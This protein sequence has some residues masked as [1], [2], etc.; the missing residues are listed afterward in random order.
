ML[1]KDVTFS[2]NSRRFNYNIDGKMPEL[3]DESPH[4]DP[5]VVL[6]TKE[7]IARVYALLGTIAPRKRSVF[8]L[9]D[10]EG[11]PQEEVAEIVGAN[12]AT[13]R[14][15]LFYARKEFWK[16]ASKDPVLSELGLKVDVS[17]LGVFASGDESAVIDDEEPS[18]SGEV[19]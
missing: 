9:N 2:E 3:I 15:R 7:T 14:S 19:G 11:I 10:L 6:Q 5:E 8:I 18:S 1:C 12:I 4:S 16:K 13:V 17:T